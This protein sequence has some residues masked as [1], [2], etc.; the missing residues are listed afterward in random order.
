MNET[1]GDVKNNRPVPEFRMNLRHRTAEMLLFCEEGE[2]GLVYARMMNAIHLS[3]FSAYRGSCRR[4][5]AK[6]PGRKMIV[7]E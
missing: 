3:I 7:S 2:D 4:T 6:R 5:P 1:G